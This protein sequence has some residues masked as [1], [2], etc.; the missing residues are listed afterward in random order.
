MDPM[1]DEQPY[2]YTSSVGFNVNM[3]FYMESVVDRLFRDQE[4]Y[5]RQQLEVV[6]EGVM[7]RPR[8]AIPQMLVRRCPGCYLPMR[9]DFA[10]DALY[11]DL[12]EGAVTREWLMKR[13][14]LRRWLDKLQGMDS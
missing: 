7:R 14:R 13:S 2:L 8:I 6:I 10:C 3:P 4:D 5:R 1:D 9:Y 11:C 12:C